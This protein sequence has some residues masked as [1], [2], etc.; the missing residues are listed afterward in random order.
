[1]SLD[2]AII[3]RIASMIFLRS[4]TF[5]CRVGAI[6]LLVS[7]GLG[8]YAQTNLG[9]IDVGANTSAAVTVTIGSAGTPAAIAV[10]TQ[11]NQNLDFTNAGGGTCAPGT[12][13]A[14]GNTCTVIVAFAPRF[15]G[16]RMGAVLLEDAGGN[17]LATAFAAGTGIG[18]QVGFLPLFGGGGVSGPADVYGVAVDAAGDVF[19]TCPTTNAAYKETPGPNGYVQT[20]IA[21]GLGTTPGSNEPLGIAVDGAGNV[22]ITDSAANRVV[23]LTPASTGYEQSDTK[24][25]GLTQPAGIAVDATGNLYVVD[26]G[27]GRILK[28]TLTPTGFTQTTVATG[29]IVP[30]GVAVDGS[31]NVFVTS[32]TGSDSLYVFPAPGSG[33]T[34]STLGT[35]TSPTAVGVDG[36]GNVYVQDQFALYRETKLSSGYSQVQLTPK[37]GTPQVVP[38]VM[39]VDG[40][41]N[42]WIG[43]VDA[44]EFGQAVMPLVGFNSTELGVSANPPQS[45][46]IMSIG[47][48]PLEITQVTFPPDFDE[49]LPPANPPDFPPE[50]ASSGECSIGQSLAVGSFCT[51]TADFAPQ[52]SLNGESSQ[53]L[54]ENL[55]F[56]TNSK[57]AGEDPGM[58]EL[59]GTE[60]APPA[61]LLLTPSAAPSIVG[62]PVTLSIQVPGTSV[63]ATGPV[64]LYTG[65]TSPGSLGTLVTVLNLDPNGRTSYTLTGLAA[66][67]YT[68][69]AYYSGDGN[70]PAAT[71]VTL[72]ISVVAAPAE[73]SFGASI[74]TVN[75]GSS[76]AM[77]PLT[78]NFTSDVT[79][80]GIAVLTQG[81]P[82][83]E[84]QDA[85]NGT[86]TAGTAYASGQSC[87]V[88][89][90]FKPLRPGPRYGAV[91]L[92]GASGSAVGT[93]YLQGT[94]HGA[95]AEFAPGTLNSLTLPSSSV[96]GLAV[97]AAGNLYIAAGNVYKLTLANGIF[98][99]T[100]IATG[101]NAY[102]IAID[103]G[104]NVYVGGGAAGLSSVFK[105]TPVNGTYV[106][107]EIGYDLAAV[108][109]IAVDGQGNVYIADSGAAT[110]SGEIYEETLVNGSYTQSIA[111]GPWESPSA[112]AVDGSGNLYVTDDGSGSGVGLFKETLANGSYTKSAIGSNWQNPTSVALDAAGN[113]Y[114]ADNDHFQGNGFVVEESLQPNGTYQS[115]TLAGTLKRPQTLAVDG[116]GNVYI[117]AA[118]GGGTS[119][120]LDVGDAPSLTFATTAK[121]A[122]STDSPKVITIENGGNAPLGFL[123]MTFPSDFPE[124]TSAAGDCN[125]ATALMPGASC[126]LTIDFTPTAEGT[127]G[128]SNPLS[129]SVLATTNGAVGML[130]IA[131]T[132]T[133]TIPAV[134]P[135]F[136]VTGTSLSVTP[137]AVNGNT[138]NINIVPSGG[139]TGSV[140]LTA[141]ITSSPAGAVDLPTFSFGTTSPVSVT[142]SNAVSATLTINTTA[143]SSSAMIRPVRSKGSWYAVGGTALACLMLAGV[144]AR[145]RWRSLLGM[146]ALLFVAMIAIGACGGG[147]SSGGGGGGGQTIPGTTAGTYTVTVTATSGN[148]SAT[149]TVGLTVE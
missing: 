16:T 74:G 46:G 106:Q 31:G 126:T 133:E 130:S 7:G 84:F 19:I 121:G 144:P 140:A 43:N 10:L 113:V 23:K 37:P 81:V 29:I 99:S 15:A 116:A 1:L 64:S 22:Y 36:V 30:Q 70:Y 88:D 61:Q 128:V 127:P 18:A 119:Y 111:G 35:F 5:V 105:L 115:S 13:Y 52:A 125:P 59:Q 92:T 147:G 80:Q 142:S 137:G 124:A 50:F 9:T 45:T 4:R 26:S 132:G 131:V 11:G 51:L 60:T 134:A 6:L 139:F 112:V 25:T 91:V 39:A 21:S 3:F 65:Q 104:G 24:I 107:T 90:I 87:T 67:T 71:A 33:F 72:T 14:A 69:N 108:E 42:I 73:N 56:T 68:Y 86:C 53:N 77:T 85:G 97:D 148:T 96:S 2:L 78:I 95:Q 27:V 20:Q 28:E 12:A 66:G 75:V 138:A 117:A 129:E 82:N 109:G 103:G 101:I 76:S 110:D 34:G 63:P 47:N 83:L 141:S 62:Q 149:G 123:S 114:V 44:Q 8:A 146:I 94:G 102:G 93:G 89:V 38:F 79:L 100:E 49:A 120:K 41:G 57:S 17:V 48:L 55:S 135:A 145:R 32:P 143:P 136:T 54:T 40:A 122:T 98:T 118:D 58:I